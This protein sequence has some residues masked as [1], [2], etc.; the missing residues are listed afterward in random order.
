MNNIKNEAYE[1][2]V[3]MY[4]NETVDKA[5]PTPILNNYVPSQDTLIA[6][7]TDVVQT[8]TLNKYDSSGKVV[9][10][11]SI[12][13]DDPNLR[14]MI[15]LRLPYVLEGFSNAKMEYPDM[16]NSPSIQS[17][18]SYVNQAVKVLSAAAAVGAASGAVLSGGGYK[19]VGRFVHSVLSVPP[20]PSPPSLSSVLNSLDTDAEAKGQRYKQ[21]GGSKQSPT[22]DYIFLGLLTVITLGGMISAVLRSLPNRTTH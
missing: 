4:K 5:N 6:I 8:L 21:T 16:A 9:S 2:A 7:D 12:S 1:Q 20:V 10:S 3:T 15:K 17:Y 11:T 22:D 13:T 18:L 14:D 19:A